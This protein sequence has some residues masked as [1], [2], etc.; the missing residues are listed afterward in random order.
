MNLWVDDE[1]EAPKG[2]WWA[3]TNAEAISWLETHRV[4]HLSLD[5]SL[6]HETTDDIMYWLQEHPEHWPTGSIVCHSSS[7]SAQHLIEHMV[8]DFAPGVPSE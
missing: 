6:K 8:R 3:A 7:S 2:W 4:E 5:Y 1:R